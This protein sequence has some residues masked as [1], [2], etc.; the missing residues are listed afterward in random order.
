MMLYTTK[1][2]INF[3]SYVYVKSAID[4]VVLSYND[5]VLCSKFIS[6]DKI[7]TGTVTSNVFLDDSKLFEDDEIVLF[8]LKNTINILKSIN[9]VFSSN[10]VQVINNSRVLSL[11]SSILNVNIPLLDKSQYPKIPV[12]REDI[13]NGGFVEFE[14][15]NDVINT[16]YKLSG[17]NK[18]YNNLY[19]NVNNTD[20]NVEFMLAKELKSSD[21]ITLAF[22]ISYKTNSYL[23]DSYMKFNL[24]Y[25]RNLFHNNRGMLKCTIRLYSNLLMDVT[26][27]HKFDVVNLKFISDDV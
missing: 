25:V 27:H 17:V 20:N 21:I 3:L 18:E 2:L 19:V 13:L 14:L 4:K 24:N 9:N 16:L 5:G 1:H 26:F 11:T 6:V 10:G 23:T 12:I 15:S 7:V 8:D 22:D